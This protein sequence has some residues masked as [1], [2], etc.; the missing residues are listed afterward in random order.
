MFDLAKNR[1]TSCELGQPVMIKEVVGRIVGYYAEG[2]W[3]EINGNKMYSI[4]EIGTPHGTVVKS[5]C[6]FID[7]ITPE[8]LE[9]LEAYEVQLRSESK[10]LYN[11]RLDNILKT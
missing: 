10:Q 6:M 3:G 1:I 7:E 5:G 2:S 8:G 11:G 4:L 9:K